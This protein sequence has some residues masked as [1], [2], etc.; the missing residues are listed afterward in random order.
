MIILVGGPK[1]GTGKST[2]AINF[3][4]TSLHNDRDVLLVDC[5]QRKKG[6]GYTSKWAA[7]RDQLGIQPRVHSMIKY[8]DGLNLE[9][10]HLARKYQDIIIDVAGHE[11]P[12]FVSSIAVA[13]VV[14]FP[15]RP[16]DPD[17]SSLIEFTDI[18]NQAKN[19]NPDLYGLVFLNQ[20]PTND[21]FAKLREGQEYLSTH[22][23]SANFDIAKKPICLRKA[24]SYALEEG[25]GI[26]ELVG[27]EA[28][29]SAVSEFTTI[30]EEV[31]SHG[32]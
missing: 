11:S 24:F 2:T 29:A 8:G 27:K 31:M 12:E 20:V 23:G 30:Y 9:L 16:N 15:V 32:T 4:V 14:V 13:D 19:F 17:L 22:Y 18:F 3:T 21:G 1:G 6:F 5:E 26:I 25:K 7:M 10:R 28:D